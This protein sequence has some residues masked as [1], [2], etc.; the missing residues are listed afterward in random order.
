VGSAQSEPTLG[1]LAGTFI[2]GSGFGQVEPKTVDNGGDPTGIVT[3]IRW[4]NWGRTQVVGTGLSDYVGPNQTVASG[5][6]QPV[7]IVA[8]DLG[9]CN[10]RYMYEAVEWYFPQH[11]QTFDPNHFE[12]VCTGTYHSG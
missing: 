10:G 4:S 7:R 2:H 3:S 12:D 1:V 5:T 8:F 6:I 11:G 9:T